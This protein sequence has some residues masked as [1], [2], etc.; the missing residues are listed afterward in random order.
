LLQN[1]LQES[2]PQVQPVRYSPLEAAIAA[3]IGGSLNAASPYTSDG[4]KALQSFVAAKQSAAEAQ[5]QN[6]V[7]Q[8]T[9][10]IQAAQQG[11]KM[12]QDE[13]NPL[14]QQAN[15]ADQTQQEVAAQKFKE[16]LQTEQQAFDSHQAELQNMHNLFMQD[17]KSSA[18]EQLQQHRILQEKLAE[19]LAQTGAGR[20][21]LAAQTGAAL[22]K[23][24][25]EIVQMA[26]I[27]VH[28]TP[29]ELADQARTQLYQERRVK[30]PLL[31]PENLSLPSTMP[32]TETAG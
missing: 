27:A 2:T 13:A 9:A 16:R 22:G 8:H 17:Q 29:K 10:A 1:A 19:V 24:P 15:A 6:E 28:A 4:T 25:G 12:A 31:P 7:A 11:Y 23:A 30:P 26:R 21:L 20:A 5:Y 32:I 3:V 18:E 14:F